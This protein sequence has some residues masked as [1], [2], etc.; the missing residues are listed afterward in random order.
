MPLVALPFSLGAAG[1]GE[2]C[3]VKPAALPADIC[4]P[5][6]WVKFPRMEGGTVKWLSVINNS[7]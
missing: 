3:R 7:L 4:V 1:T 6:L 2:G 5:D